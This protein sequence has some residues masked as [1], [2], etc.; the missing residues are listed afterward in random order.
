MQVNLIVTTKNNN[1]SIE[2]RKNTTDLELIKALV[3]CAIH[4]Q[5]ITIMPAFSDKLQAINSLID[6]G[7]I[8]VENGQYYFTF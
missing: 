8:Y 1:P 2:I 5:P 6:K 7:I 4:N 3:T